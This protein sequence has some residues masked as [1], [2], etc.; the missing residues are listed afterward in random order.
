[1]WHP[2][3]K[4]VIS[5]TS[6][7]MYSRYTKKP[8]IKAVLPYLTTHPVLHVQPIF[9]VHIMYLVYMACVHVSVRMLI[10]LHVQVSQSVV[11]SLVI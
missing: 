6:F 5:Q 2:P 7:L 9:S 11:L 4:S 10:S 8:N 1:M 3:H